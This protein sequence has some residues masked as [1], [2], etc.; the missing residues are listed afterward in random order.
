MFSPSL[1]FSLSN[2]AQIHSQLMHQKNLANTIGL[3]AEKGKQLGINESATSKLVGAIQVGE[4][5]HTGEIPSR[6]EIV[7]VLGNQDSDAEH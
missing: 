3:L 7:A 6:E 5:I 2:R 1:S 4:Y